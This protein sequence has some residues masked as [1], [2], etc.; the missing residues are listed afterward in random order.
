MDLYNNVIEDLTPLEHLEF[1]SYLRLDHNAITDLTPLSKLKYLRSLT[2]KVDK[3][4][5]DSLFKI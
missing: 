4:T 3:V 1:I 5:V 2:L